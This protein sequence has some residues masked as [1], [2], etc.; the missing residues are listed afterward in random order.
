MSALPPKSDIGVGRGHVR[1][2]PKADVR[3][4]VPQQPLAK[5]PLC[6]APSVLR[7]DP[8]ISRFKTLLYF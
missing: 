7:G 8:Y 2:G 5:G 6:R 3:S 1:H 4:R